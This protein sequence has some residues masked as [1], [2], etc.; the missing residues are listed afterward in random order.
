[1]YEANFSKEKSAVR[2]IE[3]NFGLVWKRR[4]RRIILEATFLLGGTNYS[5][6]MKSHGWLE[7]PPGA[8][9]SIGRRRISQAVRNDSVGERSLVYLGGTCLFWWFRVIQAA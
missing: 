8:V 6:G 2:F 7:V 4:W 5:H 1:V 3:Q 9:E